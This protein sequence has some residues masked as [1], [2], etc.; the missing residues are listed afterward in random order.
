MEDIQQYYA[1]ARAN[2]E[3]IHIKDAEVNGDYVCIE[4]NEEMRVRK[5]AVRAHHFSHA[6]SDKPCKYRLSH[7]VKESK[8]LSKL[9]HKNEDIR[10]I[11]W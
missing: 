6:P 11:M 10:D 8:W 3:R 4:C 1:V 5:G 7:I 2:N 9:I